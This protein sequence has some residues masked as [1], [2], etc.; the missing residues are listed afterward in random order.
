MLHVGLPNSM[1][2]EK[3]SEGRNFSKALQDHIIVGDQDCFLELQA[4]SII[5]TWIVRCIHGIIVS[6]KAKQ[7]Y[8]E[9]AF[10]VPY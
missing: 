9:H 6:T 5:S 10:H 4:K 3:Q 2:G 8:P 1:E 7:G